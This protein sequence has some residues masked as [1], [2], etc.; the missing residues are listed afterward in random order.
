MNVDWD[1]RKA[2]SNLKKHGVSFDDAA[3]VFDDPQARTLPD[4]DH[5]FDEN[6]FVT[7]GTASRGTLIVVCH[8]IEDKEV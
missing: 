2:V 4:P 5:S 1:D 3:T 6:R 8:T 7:I